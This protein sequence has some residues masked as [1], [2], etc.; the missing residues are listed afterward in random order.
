MGIWESIASSVAGTSVVR[1]VGQKTPAHSED[2]LT[3]GI[4]VV[5][6]VAKLSKADGV[7][8]RTEIESFKR[9]F[10]I[11]DS[12]LAGISKLFNMAST[13]VVG[14]EDYARQIAYRFGDR[15]AVL[16]ELLEALFC[17]A[18]ADGLVHQAELSY[19]SSV[20]QIFG[21]SESDFE[22]IRAG[23]P[24]ISGTSQSD[25]YQ[26]LGVEASAEMAT[27]KAAYHR[28][29]HQ[30][31]PDRLVAQ[32]MPEEFIEIANDKMAT[33][34]GAYNRIQYERKLQERY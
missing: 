7:V 4:G 34:N 14:F 22:R 1:L 13:E 21:L 19:L 20:A 26:I 12:Q 15:P 27:I 6:L 17:V 2:N 16:E 8:S 18:E 10:K 23:R 30:N 5:A 25:P 28:L 33:I 11:Q 24:G 31:H 29:I 9:V 32:G 3:F